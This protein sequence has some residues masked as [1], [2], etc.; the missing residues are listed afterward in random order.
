MLIAEPEY[1]LAMQT[2]ISPKADL[3]RTPVCGAGH[4]RE[5][6]CHPQISSNSALR[7]VDT[8]RCKAGVALLEVLIAAASIALFMSG[9]FAMNSF[10]LK[11]VRAGKETVAAS[12]VLQERLDQLRRGSWVNVTDPAYIQ[13]CMG[14]AAGAAVPLS[15]LVERIS[16]NAYPTPAPTPIQVTRWASGAVSVDSTNTTLR[17]ESMVRADFTATWVTGRNGATRTRTI[18]TV[19]AQGGIIQ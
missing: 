15:G 17:Q 4:R 16:I 1:Y 8:K 18:S 9:L 11:T 19:I 12:L 10:S 5:E 3:L 2:M 6:N 13:S 7:P 14:N